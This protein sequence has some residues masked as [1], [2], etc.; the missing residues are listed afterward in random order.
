MYANGSYSTE[1]R[2]NFTLNHRQQ[3]KCYPQRC[4]LAHFEATLDFSRSEFTCPIITK[5]KFVTA[6]KFHYRVLQLVFLTPLGVT[7]IL[8]AM[9]HVCI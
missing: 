9:V 7:F 2:S 5:V 6:V 3:N 4:L 1:I 8:L